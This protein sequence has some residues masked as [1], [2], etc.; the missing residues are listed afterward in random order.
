MFIDR[1]KPYLYSPPKSPQI[2]LASRM[3][4]LAFEAFQIKNISWYFYF[5]ILHLY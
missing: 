3:L 5:I 4:R 2:N 1:L